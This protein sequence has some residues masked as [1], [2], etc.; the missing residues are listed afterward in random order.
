MKNDN[1]EHKN[2]YYQSGFNPIIL[3]FKINNV[4]LPAVL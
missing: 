1:K 4:Y 3:I 2:D